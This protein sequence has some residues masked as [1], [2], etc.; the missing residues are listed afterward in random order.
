MT[1]TERLYAVTLLGFVMGAAYAA[2]SGYGAIG[3]LMTALFTAVVV[4]I[5]MILR[6]ALLAAD[7]RAHRPV[8]RDPMTHVDRIEPT[9]A[10]RR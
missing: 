7:H 5:A 2:A 4:A 3:D 6:S 8:V 1:P 9:H 10:R